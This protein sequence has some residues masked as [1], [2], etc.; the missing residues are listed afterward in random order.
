MHGSCKGDEGYQAKQVATKAKEQK[1]Q[2]QILDRS[3]VIDGY[4]VT[5]NLS[6]VYVPVLMF[7]CQTSLT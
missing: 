5:P 7:R 1:A 4:R 6:S 2:P 3:R